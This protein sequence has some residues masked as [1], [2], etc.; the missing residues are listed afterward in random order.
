MKLLVRLC[1]AQRCSGAYAQVWCL[2]NCGQGNLP[3]THL[4]IAWDEYQCPS[5]NTRLQL[6]MLHSFMLFGRLCCS[7]TLAS[8]EN[9]LLGN[10]DLVLSRCSVRILHLCWN[11]VL[12]T[13]DGMKY[14]LRRSSLSSMRQDCGLWKVIS[15]YSSWQSWSKRQKMAIHIKVIHQHA[16]DWPAQC[17]AR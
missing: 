9:V 3:N 5:C 12:N 11:V 8:R 10:W 4:K 14:Y 16:F 13:G 17:L 6:V 15:Y 7:L 2:L 1:Y